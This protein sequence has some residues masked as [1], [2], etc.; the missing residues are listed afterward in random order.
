MQ[1]IDLLEYGGGHLRLRHHGEIVSLPDPRALDFQFVL[2]IL[3][4][5]HVPGTPDDIP[6]ETAR[7]IFDRWCAA[8]DL[9]D[10][11]SARRLAYLVDH[12][13]AGI[14]YDLQTYAHLDLGTMWRE[15]RWTTLLDILD[16]LPGHSWYSATIAMDEEHANMVARIMV[17]RGT[18][19]EKADTGP[20]L[21]NYT[22]EVAAMKDVLD[23]INHLTYVLAT[24][25]SERGKGPKEPA[26]TKRPVTPLENAIKRAE[27]EIR[28]AKHDTLVARL[29]PHKAQSKS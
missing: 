9:P 29:L 4:A 28:K 13:R 3:H 16:H 10:F 26:P 15:R 27:Y 23:A 12:Y 6:L 14:S 25:N 18:N 22:P 11:G 1:S 20:S 8:W 7:L 21:T 2:R 5:E 19:E 24:V 17:E